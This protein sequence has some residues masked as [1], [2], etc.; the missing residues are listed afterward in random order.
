MASASYTQTVAV[1][2]S[3]PG[4]GEYLYRPQKVVKKM[5]YIPVFS[6]RNFQIFKFDVL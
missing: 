1:Q 6:G 5:S 2:D 3:N 4:K